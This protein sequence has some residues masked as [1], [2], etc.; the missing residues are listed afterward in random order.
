LTD[1][2]DDHQAQITHLI[3]DSERRPDIPYQLLLYEA[4]GWAAPQYAQ[5]PPILATERRDAGTPLG[6]A[7]LD[8]YRE[9]GYLA[10]AVVN[11]VARL[12]WASRGKR[13]LLSLDELA[14]RFDL[15]RVS[16]RPTVHDTRPLDWFNHRYLSGLDGEAVTRLVRPYWQRAYGVA[17]RAEGTALAGPAWQRTLALALRDELH[18]LAQV[19][20]KVDYF[21]LDETTRTPAAEAMLGQVY[22]PPILKA[23]IQGIAELEPFDYATI[24]AFVSDLR[25]RFKASHGVRS[26]DVMHVVRA[27]LS[28]RID[29]PC[30]VVACQLLGQ[31]RCVE[32]ARASAFNR[33]NLQANQECRVPAGAE[34]A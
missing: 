9:R 29:G 30:L 26:R 6:D 24:D 1:V 14:R 15:R 11:H 25:W 5:L 3:R 21:F 12:G 17:D 32:R 8:A 19:P 16:R 20:E 2:V 31:Q 27:A 22:A 33:Q 4:L 18:Y 10:P 28:G 7:S 23:F 13:E 34:Q